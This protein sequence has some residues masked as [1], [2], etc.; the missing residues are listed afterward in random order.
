MSSDIGTHALRSSASDERTCD[1]SAIIVP[2]A[3][4]PA[5]ELVTHEVT[6]ITLCHGHL[7]VS[8]HDFSFVFNYKNTKLF[9]ELMYGR[10]Y[11]KLS[12][13][14]SYAITIVIGLNSQRKAHRKK[15]WQQHQIS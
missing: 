7:Q 5:R 2:C 15:K 12:T 9:I 10:Q 13:T 4:P 1:G 14:V 3:T 8:S 6:K 11:I